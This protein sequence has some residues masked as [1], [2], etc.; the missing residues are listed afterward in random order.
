MVPSV[1]KL[2]TYYHPDGGPVLHSPL[3]QVVIDDGRRFLE[4]S[5]QKYD[6]I[7]ID[8]PPPV[9]A[10]GS[11]LLYSRDFYEDEA[12]QHLHPGG[13]LQQWLPGG[14]DPDQASVAR[15]LTDSFQYVRAYSS[16]ENIGGRSVASLRPIPER[17]AEEL[18][19]GIPPS[20][21]VA[22]MMEWGPARTPADQF[23][24]MLLR[25]VSPSQRIALDPGIPAVQEGPSCLARQLCRP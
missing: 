17:T 4:R 8:P 24:R 10:A 23:R 19:A 11:S 1:P 3:A 21:A 2:F 12:K 7:I 14:D 5:G 22:D 18:V 13:I 9:E 16:V 20:S 15:A 25:K 6:A